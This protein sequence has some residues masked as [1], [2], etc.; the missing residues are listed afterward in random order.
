MSDLVQKNQKQGG[1][2]LKEAREA[3]GISLE[4]VHASTKIPMDALK[5][6][7]EGYKVRVLTPFYIKG[8]MKMYAQ[9]LGIDVSKVLEDYHVEQLPPHISEDKKGLLIE[10]AV[11]HFSKE[12]QKKSFQIIGVV[13]LALV[14]LKVGSAVM[15]AKSQKKKEVKPNIVLT[16]KDKKPVVP[17]KTPVAPKRVENKA[18][19][20]KA[21]AAVESRAP[22]EKVPVAKPETTAIEEEAGEEKTTVAVKKVRLT[23]RAKKSGWLQVKV[24]GNLVFQSTLEEGSTESWAAAKIIELSGKNIHNLEFEVNGKVVGGLGRED[25]SARRVIITESGLTVKNSL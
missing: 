5:S 2:I 19:E 17:G 12:Q 11:V 1:Q 21:V 9:Y 4:T 18:I 10:K 7:E 8:F 13:V 20:K 24:D 15:V 16:Q 6:I 22:K 3:Q 14:F 23:I 25:R